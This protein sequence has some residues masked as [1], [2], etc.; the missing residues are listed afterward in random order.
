[1]EP[2]YKG[3]QV[4][5]TFIVI[6]RQRSDAVLRA[7]Q[8]GN[9]D[10]LSFAMVDQARSMLAGTPF[11]QLPML[12]EIGLL[13]PEGRSGPTGQAGNYAARAMRA[14]RVL[15]SVGAVLIDE[16]SP[17]QLEAL[18]EQAIVLP[19]A[20][21]P[22][23]GPVEEKEQTTCQPWHL[24]KINVAAAHKKGLDGRGIRI[25]IVDTGIDASHKEFKGKSIDFAE[26]DASGF[27]ISTV[28]RDAGSHGTHVSALAAGLTCGVAPGADLSVAAVL[29]HNGGKS[30]FLAQILGGLNWLAH[31]NHPS[32]TTP[33]AHCPIMNGSFGGGGYNPYL[34]STLQ[35]VRS[36]PA[37]L[38]SA[39]IGNNGRSGVNLHG[40]PGNY[41]IVPGV[42][43]TDSKDDPAPFSDWGVEKTSGAL[44]P[45]LS[46][47]GVDICSA[48]PGNRYG[49]KSGTSMAAPMVAGAAALLIQQTPT[50][51]RNPTGLLV[52][53]LRLVDT[54]PASRPTATVS[55][56]N[57]I[58]M[59]RLDLTGI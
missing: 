57:R 33:I 51:A 47:P 36:A 25:G 17:P 13:A 18:Q 20:D 15:S 27:L 31:S 49:L 38:F 37:S 24:T 22:L 14:P 11:G 2:N 7:Q 58:G 43:A 48:L 56:Y 34:L 19:N 44:K 50:F 54:A 5:Q 28:P 40:S 6:P 21:V 52:R 12:T 32:P 8:T 30:G 26:F 9:Q 46:A 23:V 45:D 39:A 42:G 41:D 59:G 55:G 3:L 53:L 4:V 16:L 29:T 10:T 35:T 1:V